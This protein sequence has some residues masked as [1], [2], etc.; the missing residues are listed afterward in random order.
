[1]KYLLKMKKINRSGVEIANFEQS[2]DDIKKINKKI[3]ELQAA[4]FLNYK[5]YENGKLWQSNYKD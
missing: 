5:I 3:D 2:F 1:M 4:G